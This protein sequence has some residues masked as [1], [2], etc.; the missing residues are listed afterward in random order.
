M[1]LQL[2]PFFILWLNTVQW[3][4]IVEHFPE[5]KKQMQDEWTLKLQICGKY[6]YFLNENVRML[7]WHFFMFHYGSMTL[8]IF[9]NCN[10]NCYLI[11]LKCQKFSL[12]ITPN[13]VEELWWY[14]HIW[15]HDPEMN[16]NVLI[17]IHDFTTIQ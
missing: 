7:L 15:M 1:D 14:K 16:C 9:Y 8:G 12:H 5:R 11:L 2:Y 6:T 4:F 10:S 13:N 3:W 17:K